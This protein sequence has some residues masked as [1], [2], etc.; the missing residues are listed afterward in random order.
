[1]ADGTEDWNGGSRAFVRLDS[2]SFFRE[3]LRQ[4]GGRSCRLGVPVCRRTVGCSGGLIGDQTGA[5]NVGQTGT[6]KRRCIT[7]SF[8]FSFRFRLGH[9]YNF[10]KSYE[11]DLVAGEENTHHVSHQLFVTHATAI[12]LIRK[13]PTLSGFL[14]SSE[15]TVFPPITRVSSHRTLKRLFNELRSV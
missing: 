14:P 1:M 5:G 9:E 7:V 12:N 10:H 6:L 11:L 8:S 2:F 3:H 15:E 4:H 13:R